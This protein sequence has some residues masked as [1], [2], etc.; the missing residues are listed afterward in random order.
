MGQPTR[1]ERMFIKGMRLEAIDKETGKI[2][3]AN[4]FTI[5]MLLDGSFYGCVDRHSTDRKIL[6]LRRKDER[7]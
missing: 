1:G 6:E 2:Y 3:E 5:V 7:D 4:E